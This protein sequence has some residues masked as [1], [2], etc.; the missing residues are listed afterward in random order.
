[1]GWDFAE[2]GLGGRNR[3]AMDASLRGGSTFTATLAWFRQREYD[4]LTSVA[5][6]IAQANLDLIVR[7]IATGTVARSV[8]LYN[9]VEHLS[10]VLPASGRYA[11][12][13][14]YGSNT[15]DSR[16]DFA[17]AG[18]GLAWWAQAPAPP[19]PPLLLAGT[20]ALLLSRRRRRGI[21]RAARTAEG[22]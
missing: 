13:V 2:V 9:L 12:D 18:Y 17:L 21:T 5:D 11:I 8:S 3:Y 16:G 10:F 1:V 20:A 19:V 6:D 7:D 14:V 4:T 15:F 22:P